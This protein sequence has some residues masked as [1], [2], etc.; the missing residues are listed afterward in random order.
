MLSCSS[1]VGHTFFAMHLWLDSL[2]LDA[3]VLL[4]PGYKLAW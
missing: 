1:G 2:L 4:R 3:A